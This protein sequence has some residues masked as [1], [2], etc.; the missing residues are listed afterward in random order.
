MF[1]ATLLGIE[2]I[3]TLSAKLSTILICLALWKYTKSLVPA[4]SIRIDILH[5]AFVEVKIRRGFH[6]FFV[7]SETLNVALSSAYLVD[8]HVNDAQ[9]S[10]IFNVLDLDGN[11]ELIVPLSPGRDV[12]MTLF[13]S[14]T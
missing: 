5:A 2:I 3:Y 6:G 7:T 10:L 9:A 8:E 11:G 1:I 4:G 13:L 14:L 12:T